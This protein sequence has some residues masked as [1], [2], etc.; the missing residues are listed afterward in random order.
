MGA[1]DGNGTSLP[2]DGIGVISG[3]VGLEPIFAAKS[4]AANAGTLLESKKIAATFISF[5]AIGCWSKWSLLDMPGFPRLNTF[6]GKPRSAFTLVELLVVISI[7]GMLMLLIGPAVQSARNAARRLECKNNVV[8]LVKGAKQHV[9]VWGRYPTGGWGWNWIGDSERGT[10][11]KQPGGW[12]FNILPYIDQLAL[13]DLDKGL[14]PAAKMAKNTIRL[15]QPFTLANCQ[16]RRRSIT[17]PYSGGNPINATKV[18]NTC[19]TDYAASCGTNDSAG[20]H[21]QNG[22]GPA[23]MDVWDKTPPA[24]DTSDGVCYRR[25]MVTPAMVLDGEQYVYL[26]GEKFVPTSHY[27]DGGWGAENETLYT[28]YN[29]DNYR[30]GFSQPAMDTD[31]AVPGALCAFGSVH[32][33]GLNMGMCDGSVRTIKYSISLDVHKRLA[34]RADGNNP[35]DKE[36]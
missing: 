3:R 29:N 18:A 21:C 14:A 16:M 9:T 2:A 31:D 33:I 15:S 19:R 1:A 4:L 26:I 17:Y 35:G 24:P 11:E 12:L 22:A 36:F 13:Y 23:S 27:Q 5:L 20:D 25:S 30:S 28:G 8:G 34:R 32:D 10:N 7:I 6:A